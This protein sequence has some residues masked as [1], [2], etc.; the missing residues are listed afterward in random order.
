MW[1]GCRLRRGPGHRTG[2]TREL[3]GEGVQLRR[4][5]DAVVGFEQC[6]VR[7][8]EA[9]GAGPV[10][11]GRHGARE[12]DRNPRVVRVQRG[13]APPGLGSRHHLTARRAV[14]GEGFSSGHCR[15]RQGG[16]LGGQ[17]LLVRVRIGQVEPIEERPTEGFQ[18][19]GDVV[20]CERSPE[21]AHVA[22]NDR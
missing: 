8:D 19:G 13:R 10:T 7:A 2:R 22:L 18:G 16:A 9:N 11:R 14:G 15:T 5:R 12:I 17:P 21:G 4:R 3:G 20:A 1:F 6:G